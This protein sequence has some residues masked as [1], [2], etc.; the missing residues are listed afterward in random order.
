[1]IPVTLSLGVVTSEAVED[2]QTFIATA[3]AALYRAKDGGRNRL[4]F[5]TLADVAAG[6]PLKDL[7]VVS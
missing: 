4:E 3:D 1:V 5:A 6:S 7:E 2:V